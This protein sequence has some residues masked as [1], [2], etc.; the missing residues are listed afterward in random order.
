MVGT[1]VVDGRWSALA[2]VVMTP[3]GETGLELSVDWES[4]TSD[5]NNI[6]ASWVTAVPVDGGVDSVDGEVDVIADDVDADVSAD[7]EVSS[8][9]EDVP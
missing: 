1:Y 5:G 2:D 9:D 8:V 3:T 6:T 4:V 7:T